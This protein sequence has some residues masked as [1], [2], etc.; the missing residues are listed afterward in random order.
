MLQLA[1]HT[2][3]P[4]MILALPDPDG[5]DALHVMVKATFALTDA[6]P[7]AEEQRPIAMADEWVGEGESAWLLRPSE[8]HPAKPATDVMLEGVATAPH[9]RAVRELDVAV[10]VGPL[11]RALRVIGDRRY[12]GLDAPWCT[13]PDA[14]TRMP[15]TPERAFGGRFAPSGLVETRNP[16]GVGLAPADLRD[17]RALRGLA[18]PNVE[19]PA[20]RM[21]AP[22]DRPEP[23]LVT[24]VASSWWPRAPLAGTYD[25]AWDRTRA[26][27]LPEDFDP[28][29]LQVASERMR[30]AP[31]L[32]GGEPIELHNLC[33]EPLVRSRVPAVDLRVSAVFRGAERWLAPRIESLHLFSS[34]GVAT[35]LWRATLRCG[36]RLLDVSSVEITAGGLS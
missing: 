3:L 8:L 29:F 33:D 2:G 6:A 7:F 18:L 12:T 27:F 23:A 5:V 19:D 17:R 34:E 1:N 32:R 10:V 35:V 31:H 15:L 14:F 24:P 21:R 11:R 25:D 28:R 22:G 16:V 30:V 4:A 36:H 13:D 26:P 20:A 9:G